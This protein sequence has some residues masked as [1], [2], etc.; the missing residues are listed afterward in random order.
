MDSECRTLRNSNRPSVEKHAAGR[1]INRGYVPMIEK[2]PAIYPGLLTK[3]AAVGEERGYDKS[4]RIDRHG[5]SYYHQDLRIKLPTAAIVCPKNQPAELHWWE[6][7]INPA[8]NTVIPLV[9]RV[10]DCAYLLQF[11]FPKF[12][13]RPAANQYQP[14]RVRTSDTRFGNICQLIVFIGGYWIW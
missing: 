11:N 1:A 5:N 3:L 10:T 13:T 6:P 8:T 2:G 12:T 9:R 7:S 14:E 4:Y